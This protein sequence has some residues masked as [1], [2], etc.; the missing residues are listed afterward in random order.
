[1]GSARSYSGWTVEEITN[2]FIEPVDITPLI[3]YNRII[4][5]ET[6]ML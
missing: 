2:I 4:K 1:M 5:T 6:G 3:L